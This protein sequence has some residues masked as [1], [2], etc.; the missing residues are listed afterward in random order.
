MTGNDEHHDAIF[1]IVLDALNSYLR[2]HSDGVRPDVVQAALGAIV[3]DTF[4]HVSSASDRQLLLDSFC[5]CL[6]EE[7]ANIDDELTAMK[8]SLQ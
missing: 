5:E 6:R 1:V 3:V 7:V 4:A 8:R 2:Q